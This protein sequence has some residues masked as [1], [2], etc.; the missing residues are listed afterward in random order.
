VSA[1]ER[2]PLEDLLPS[3]D[4]VSRY[5]A[6]WQTLSK[7][8]QLMELRQY[9]HENIDLIADIFPEGNR[10]PNVLNAVDRFEA[11]VKSKTDLELM[12]GSTG[13]IEYTGFFFFVFHYEDVDYPD[14]RR[15]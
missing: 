11:I 1:V 2:R 5:I 7:D 3:A 13:S 9:I 15:S 12:F 14:L 10:D 6:L 4:H 8:E